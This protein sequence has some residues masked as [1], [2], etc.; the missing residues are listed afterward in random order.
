MSNI[1]AV[2]GS[3]G[4]VKPPGCRSRVGFI[5]NLRWR[6][7]KSATGRAAVS[8]GSGMQH[9]VL[10]SVLVALQGYLIGGLI[11]CFKACFIRCMSCPPAG[12]GWG[13]I[14]GGSIGSTGGGLTGGDHRVHHCVHQRPQHKPGRRG[15]EWWHLLPMLSGHLQDEAAENKCNMATRD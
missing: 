1:S 6:R 13:C 5:R 10:H 14:T 12:L 7:V 8:P 15:S 3:Q 11:G 9:R 4:Q 2:V